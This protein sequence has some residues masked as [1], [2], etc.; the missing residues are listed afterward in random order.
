M[1]SLA[2][3]GLM[4]MSRGLVQIMDNL[5]TPEAWIKSYELSISKQISI[6]L[7]LHTIPAPATL[8]QRRNT[9]VITRLP[10]AALW[11]LI[12]A[13]LLFAIF[14]CV[15]ATLAMK[16]TSPEVHQIHV[17]LSTAGLAAQLFDA[18]KAQY[19]ANDDKGLFRETSK[20]RMGLPGKR[21]C[22]KH[23]AHGGMEYITH[24]A[25]DGAL[26]EPA[27]EAWTLRQTHTL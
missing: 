21:T 15:L 23:T 25:A 1:P 19:R 13:N 12:T 4:T 22:L 27:S 18:S 5:T 14:G 7:V 11:L 20:E 16:V 8:A 17:R 3:V 6:P 2:S 24:N 9:A 10:K 26:L